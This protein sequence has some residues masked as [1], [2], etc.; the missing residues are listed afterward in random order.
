MTL[1]G[2]EMLSLGTTKHVLSSLAVPR[3]IAMTPA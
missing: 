2:S 1:T 3:T